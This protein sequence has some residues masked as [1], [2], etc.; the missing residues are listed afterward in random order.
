MQ[1]GETEIVAQAQSLL[2]A[3]ATRK[4]KKKRT[5]LISSQG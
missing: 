3:A 2:R 4:E 1:N 5:P